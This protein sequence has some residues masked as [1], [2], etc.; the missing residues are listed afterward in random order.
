MS[1]VFPRNNQTSYLGKIRFTL[2]DEF[3]QPIDGGGDGEVTMN[4]EHQ[5]T[6][7]NQVELYL[8]QGVQ[9]ADKMEY[10][11]ASLGAVGGAAADAGKTVSTLPSESLMSEDIQKRFIGDLVGK[12]SD[13]AANIAAARNRQTPNPNTRALFK[14][15]TP[16][17]FAFN[18]KL[19]P[20]T[21]DEAKDIDRIIKF[22]RTEMYPDTFG[23][24]TDAG[25]RVDLGYKFP[26]RFLVEMVY[27][28]ETIGPKIAPAYIDSFMTNFNATSQTFFKG[29]GNK[30]YFSEVDIALTLMESKAL[31]RADIF[32][33]F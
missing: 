5:S 11:N 7:I 19:I 8:P 25:V 10:E 22:F 26:N 27:D 1:I 31:T 14:Q 18:F 16:R 21:E 13:K 24:T 12:F 15:V 9:F 30:A 23:I 28:K 33:G 6:G 3:E 29:N 20:T 32:K 2:V 17:N 4:E